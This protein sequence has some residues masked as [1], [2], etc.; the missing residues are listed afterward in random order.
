[1]A[2][3]AASAL[4]GTVLALEMVYELLLRNREAD[5]RVLGASQSSDTQ[6][7]GFPKLAAHKHSNEASS[8]SALAF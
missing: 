4:A 3:H 6:Q 5:W 2:R 1:M 7:K 8:G